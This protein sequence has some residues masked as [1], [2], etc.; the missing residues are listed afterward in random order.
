M[1]SRQLVIG[2]GLL[3][4]VAFAWWVL[5]MD[6]ASEADVDTAGSAFA[7]APGEAE[8]SRENR[9]GSLED[10]ESDAVVSRESAV[11]D[12]EEE[13]AEAAKMITF[14]GRC[15][16]AETGEPLAGCEVKLHG[17]GTNSSDEAM[18][19]EVEW[20]DPPVQVTGTDGRFFLGFPDLNPFQYVVDIRHPGRV[21]RSGRWSDD[22]TADNPRDFGD[23]AL[24]KANYHRC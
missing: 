12:T 14:S 11:A 21:T 19:A 16:A 24:Q 5:Q 1:S 13:A 9:A 7:H 4:L 18:R 20:E 15:V 8:D 17:F 10:S 2:G 3:S 6:G 23:I 22:L